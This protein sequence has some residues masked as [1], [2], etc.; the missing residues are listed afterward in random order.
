MKPE[1]EF[2]WIVNLLNSKF[3]KGGIFTESVG[4]CRSDFE[5]IAKAPENSKE[6][7][8]WFKQLIEDGT[9]ELVN[10]NESTEKKRVNYYVI[11]GGLLEGKLMENELYKPA[12]GVFYK[13]YK[14]KAGFF[15]LSK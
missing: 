15:S 8:K 4:G 13:Y 14:K 7:L 1:I 2:K 3:L 10:N 9:F 12:K 5:K 6:F 11:N